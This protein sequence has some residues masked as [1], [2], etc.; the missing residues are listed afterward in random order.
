MQEK[1]YDP[2]GMEFDGYWL[3][4]GKK[5]E[6]ALG[7]LNLT[8]RDFAKI[9]SLFLHKG[10][11]KGQQIVS[12]DWV[13]AS[14]TPDAPHVQP[15]EDDFGYGYQWWIPKGTEGEFMALGVYNQ[16]IYINPTTKTVIV[17]LS[18]NPEFNNSSYVPSSSMAAL[19]MYRVIA[20][21]F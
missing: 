9:G 7:G 15:T 17:K 8:L 3:I 12:E 2:L 4:D 18:A 14:V 10:N 1:L 20:H 11:W 19:E 13:K 21:S 5:M 16:N 6:M